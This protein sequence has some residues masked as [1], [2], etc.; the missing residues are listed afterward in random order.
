MLDNDKYIFKKYLKNDRAFFS[1]L[2]GIGSIVIAICAIIALVQG[3]QEN[4]TKY[5]TNTIIQSDKLDDAQIT[6]TEK[7][8]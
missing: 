4:I 3:P 2:L 6:S 8:L 5:S 7:K 1:I